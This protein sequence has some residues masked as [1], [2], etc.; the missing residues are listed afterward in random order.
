[1]NKYIF[2]I[3]GYTLIT[4]CVVSYV[5]VMYSLLKP[6][7]VGTMDKP[8]TNIGFPFKYYY[9]FWLK[10]SDSPNW[11]WNIRYFV[12]DLALIFLVILGGVLF[13]RKKKNK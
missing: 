10:N 2:K 6:S 5:S 8:I 12:Y 9:Q 11:G 3:I 13:L 7:L 4:F 1:M